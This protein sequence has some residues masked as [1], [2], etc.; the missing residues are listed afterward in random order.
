MRRSPV[1]M[2]TP[3]AKAVKNAHATVMAVNV[4]HARTA[5]TARTMV[6]LSPATVTMLRPIKM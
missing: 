3:P 6:A 2:A 5:V 4:A 1:W